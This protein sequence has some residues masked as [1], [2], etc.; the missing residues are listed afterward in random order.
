MGQHPLLAAADRQELNRSLGGM[1]K[2]FRRRGG[3]LANGKPGGNRTARLLPRRRH[4]RH[5]AFVDGLV[6]I[7]WAQP[8][9]GRTLPSAVRASASSAS[10]SRHRRL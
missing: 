3:E 7:D 2:E 9:L 8:L 10:A 4:G 6:D 1:T 5:L